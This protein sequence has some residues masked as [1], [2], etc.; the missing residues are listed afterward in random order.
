M[1]KAIL[2]FISV[3]LIGTITKAQSKEQYLNNFKSLLKE[4]ESDFQNVLGKELEVDSA[5]KSTYYAC[6]KGLSSSFE[7]ICINKGDNT[8]YF[9]CEYDYSKTT[10]L[11]KANEILPG[12][13]DNI[14]SMI[15]SGK[16]KGRDYK[17]ARGED[18]TEVKDLEGNYIVEIE[19]KTDVTSNKDNYLKITVY[20]KSW[21]KK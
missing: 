7:A 19:S 4:A 5:R 15:K 20:G 12:I 8:T 11:I 2:I 18:V 14:N 17:N 16:Y 13:I 6:T 1:K 10:E 3:L 9:T 21:G